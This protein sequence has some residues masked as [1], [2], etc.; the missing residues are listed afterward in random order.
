M[1]NYRE[2]EE[3]GRYRDWLRAGQQSSCPGRG[4]VSLLCMSFQPARAQAASCP[5]DTGGSFPGGEAAGA[6][7]WP[8]ISN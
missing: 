7:S 8:I 6:W 5:V 4:K 3:R 2:L 1:H